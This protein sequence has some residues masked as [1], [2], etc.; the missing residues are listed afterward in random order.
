MGADGA[1]C[2]RDAIVQCRPHRRDA[3]A[4][5]LFLVFQKYSLVLAAIALIATL[6][7]RSLVPAKSITAIFVLLGI[8]ALRG[9][10]GLIW[11]VAPMEVLRAQGLSGSPQFMK[12]HGESM[13][14]FL[15]EV[16]LLAI[17]GLIFL[18]RLARQ[19]R[20]K[21]LNLLWRKILRP[22]LRI[23]PTAPPAIPL[24]QIPPSPTPCEV[25]FAGRKKACE[26]IGRTRE[27]ILP[28]CRPAA[29]A[30]GPIQFW[31]RPKRLWRKRAK[32]FNLGQHLCHH[33]QRAIRIVVARSAI[34]RRL[35][36]GR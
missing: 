17:C 1:V 6:A 36:F 25:S 21:I 30:R 20:E 14:L 33:A 5:Q 29:C 12:L 2:F 13:G 22:E 15:L 28:T 26:Q 16:I 4:P 23:D 3:G 9:C 31:R 35:L 10:G 7:W 27:R 24:F 11:I 19:R 8:A 34:D 18:L 32:Q